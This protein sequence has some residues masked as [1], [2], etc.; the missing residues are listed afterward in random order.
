MAKKLWF[1]LIAGAAMLLLAG[2]APGPMFSG[3]KPVPSGSSELIVYRKSC[4]LCVASGQPMPLFIDGNRVGYLYNGSFFRERLRPGWHSID[5]NTLQSD[6]DGRFYWARTHFDIS[7]GKRLFLQLHYAWGLPGFTRKSEKVALKELKALKSARPPGSETSLP[8]H[9][10]VESKQKAVMSRAAARKG[11]ALVKQC[12]EAEAHHKTSAACPG[13]AHWLSKEAAL[14]NPKAEFIL[15]TLY[16]KGDGVPK[17]ERRAGVLYLKAAQQG[18]KA[19]M[20]GLAYLPWQG[21]RRIYASL[22]A[23]PED[24]VFGGTPMRVQTLSTDAPTAGLAFSP[25]GRQLAAFLSDK[26]SV[27]IWS[28]RQDRVLRTLRVGAGADSSSTP[29]LYSGGGRFVMACHRPAAHGVVANVWNVRTGDT[30]ARIRT[31]RAH[32]AGCAAAAFSPDGET[33]FVALHRGSHGGGTLV[34]YDTQT[35]RRRWGL[36]LKSFDPVALTVSPYGEHIALGGADVGRTGT[37][38]LAFKVVDRETHRTVRNERMDRFLLKQKTDLPLTRLLWTPRGLRMANGG[39]EAPHS[40]AIDILHPTPD[41]KYQV[42]NGPGHTVEITTVSWRVVETIP[43][44]GR[45]IALSRSE[46]YLATAAENRVMVWKLGQREN[47]SG[48]VKGESQ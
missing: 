19:G 31:Q 8:T 6:A 22:K 18:D 17:S 28:W 44:Q 39:R 35:W 5:V 23:V 27:R 42:V 48:D 26:R 10:T 21:W 20:A 37:P 43:A 46:T 34:A 41:G 40:H 16:Q 2:C 30:V 7:A 33:L 3:L 32:S 11:E 12:T 38:Q 29:V 45:H 14:G 13:A 47:G 24:V 25:N 36:R 4:P 9:R 15:G 1:M